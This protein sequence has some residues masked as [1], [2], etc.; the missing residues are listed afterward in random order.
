MT[1]PDPA[2][3][4]V[5]IGILLTDAEHAVIRQAGDL[6]GAICSVVGDGPTRDADLREMITHVHAIQH[7]I[8]AQAAHR[9]YPEHYRP[10]GGV[11]RTTEEPA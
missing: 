5:A 3:D 8:M 6:W 2:G 10:L 9:A 4:P 11:R 1:D 7:A